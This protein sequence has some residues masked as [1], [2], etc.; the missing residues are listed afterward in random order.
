MIYEQPLYRPPS[1]AYSLILQVTVGCK[2]NSCSFC[3][4]YK[5]KRFRVKAWEEIKSDIDYCKNRYLNTN[6][7]FLADGDALAMKT[8]MLIQILDYL[9]KVFPRLERVAIYG[10]P[11]DLL[12]KSLGELEKIRNHGIQLIYMGIESGSNIILKQIHKGVNSK[13]MIEAGKK[14]ITAGFDLSATLILG[15][16]GS[17][18]TEEHA[19]ESA[20]VASAIA[21]NYLALLTLMVME[22]TPLYRKIEKNEFTLLTAEQSLSE[23]KMIIEN[24]ELTNCIFRCNHASNYLPIKG[25]LNRDKERLV[26]MLESVLKNPDQVKLKPDFLRGL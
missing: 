4:M 3:G 24:L 6:R 8:E 23:L 22:N 2:H 14:A 10:G 15:L 13:Q 18:M 17:E 26:N 25:I 19:L 9:Y 7:V 21:P 12:E 16:G 20:K 5:E 11:K 1:E